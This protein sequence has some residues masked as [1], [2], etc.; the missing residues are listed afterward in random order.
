MVW[1]FYTQE[2]ERIW[3]IEH[4]DLTFNL[5]LI[6]GKRNDMKQK[7]IFIRRQTSQRVYQR[8]KNVGHHINDYSRVK[9]IWIGS[10]SNAHPQK[11]DINLADENAYFIS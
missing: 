9:E 1:S 11:E 5:Y 6:Y 4:I 3:E 8:F 7:N 2:E 10:F